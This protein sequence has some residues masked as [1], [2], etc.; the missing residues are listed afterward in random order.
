VSVRAL[1]MYS[2][3]ANVLA[4]GHRYEPSV[5]ADDALDDREG[6]TVQSPEL[7]KLACRAP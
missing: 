5:F 6:R 2:L 7:L 3:S 1:D 4:L